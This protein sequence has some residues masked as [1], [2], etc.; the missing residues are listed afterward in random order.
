MEVAPFKGVHLPQGLCAKDVVS[1]CFHP[2]L[3]SVYVALKG[4]VV[5]YDIVTGSKV[6]DFPL[7]VP[8]MEMMVLP[9][10]TALV[11]CNVDGSVV[12]IDFT[13]GHILAEH[14]TKGEK[15]E[16]RF[17][18][19]TLYGSQ[20]IF[21]RVKSVSAFALNLFSTNKKLQ[22]F[23]GHN[24]AITCMSTHP[25]LPLLV[26]A[27][28][29]GTVRVFEIT[30]HGLYNV[31][32]AER[33]NKDT[34]KRYCTV[35]FHTG[36]SQAGKKQRSK[37]KGI[38]SYYKN[39]KLLLVAEKSLIIYYDI[40]IPGAPNKLRDFYAPGVYYRDAC[41]HP[42]DSNVIFSMDH[43]G[44]Y[45]A[46]N[47]EGSGV[48][49][50]GNT[51][52]VSLQP[53]Q[54]KKKSK[55]FKPNSCAFSFL[56][57]N[58]NIANLH[59]PVKGTGR[60]GIAMHTA[61]TRNAI[62][63]AVAPHCPYHCFYGTEVG[64]D[65]ARC[66]MIYKLQ[67]ASK[68]YRGTGAPLITAISPPPEYWVNPCSRM[69]LPGV[70]YSLSGRG[71]N[72]IVVRAHD[73]VS[74]THETTVFTPKTAGGVEM[75]HCTPLAISHST[76][77]HLDITVKHNG[78]E[79]QG[80]VYKTTMTPK[81]P[82]DK[83][84]KQEGF[85]TDT[86]TVILSIKIN[87]ETVIAQCANGAGK[88]YLQKLKAD[89]FVPI[90]D[91]DKTILLD[92]EEYFHEAVVMQDGGHIG[93]ATTSRVIIVDENL[94][95]KCVRA[96]GGY[97]PS[98]AA[99]HWI[100]SCLCFTT[101]CNVFVMTMNGDVSRIASIPDCSV[102][103]GVLYDRLLVATAFDGDDVAI[104]SKH[105][106][107]FETLCKGFLS[108]KPD[109]R[110]SLKP[111]TASYNCTQATQSLLHRLTESGLG[112]LA[113]QLSNYSVGLSGNPYINST[114]REKSKLHM[115]SGDLP[116]AL[117]DMKS[118]L[119][120]LR[121]EVL[122][123]RVNSVSNF[124][125]PPPPGPFIETG[126]LLFQCAVHTNDTPTAD[127]VL[128]LMNHPFAVLAY[129]RKVND[130][131]SLAKLAE[132]SK[133]SVVK[134][135]AEKLPEV[136]KEKRMKY[137]VPALKK[138][139]TW[140]I[141]TTS[142]GVSCMET[143]DGEE[144]DLPRMDL[145]DLKSFVWGQQPLEHGEAGLVQ[146]GFQESD[147]D[148]GED[149]EIE[150]DEFAFPHNADDDVKSNEGD[151]DEIARQQE[152]LRRQY[153]SSFAGEDGE[154]N[155][156]EEDDD[157]FGTQRKFKKFTI[158]K[159][160]VYKQPTL[161]S[162]QLGFGIPQPKQQPDQSKDDTSS[163][164]ASPSPH[165]EK[166]PPPS[167]LGTSPSDCLRNAM[168]KLEKSRFPDAIKRLEA[169]RFYL[170]EDATMVAKKTPLIQ[171]THYILCCR[172]L[173]EVKQLEKDRFEDDVKKCAV[174]TFL[175]SKLPLQKKHVLQCVKLGVRWC[176][177]ACYYTLAK[178]IIESSTD[179]ETF[180]DQLEQCIASA[181]SDVSPS[182]EPYFS[183][184]DQSFC[185]KTFALFA[186]GGADTTQTTCTYC[187]AV[188]SGGTPGT[189]CEFCD[190]GETE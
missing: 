154:A 103:A 190:Y 31:I 86:A 160:A 82:P 88:V 44:C 19:V 8:P 132:L 80:G 43:K 78:R 18:C 112:D 109:P 50:G 151:E 152:E 81:G 91:N 1:V 64:K 61:A 56:S 25:T 59:I 187:P 7:S 106:N 77:G 164:P 146:E 9:S 116:S 10:R 140:V 5:E 55:V 155:G 153:L 179:S 114:W 157:G 159:E 35:K 126:I 27:A 26:C 174:I 72:K 167:F 117:K 67:S 36:G 180:D 125:P 97:T 172:I 111:L 84:V 38:T 145:T 144:K 13:D 30:S 29:D 6:G 170:I 156:E 122:G 49:K 46:L 163:N 48:A 118:A 175:A 12:V 128:E 62:S 14:L 21:S 150:N 119:E 143:I 148:D 110:S 105:A 173:A 121:G 99:I 186:D 184:T 166:P 127:G 65:S 96:P 104:W 16:R 39:V 169:A 123:L 68:R 60:H 141:G 124:S 135:I 87:E 28:V 32:E 90:P 17:E 3:P 94:A 23:T 142:D 101:H 102:I 149:D 2:M 134:K 63:V 139:Q 79:G 76:R 177:E 89:G 129:L 54:D 161:S 4:S 158:N 171:V 85:T 178:H 95:I 131:R 40:S 58:E 83:F 69:V 133:H 41:F 53:L 33:E 115:L 183:A 42:G 108:H 34:V 100:G 136:I 92:P 176:M 66:L 75:E 113:A 182:S 107:H 73:I 189:T 71:K 24:T 188:I 137:P 120:N 51:P 57:E 181:A 37:K 74:S 20:L 70:V 93:I 138:T 165:P 98:I 52:G 45:S 162:L 147:D 11:V 130:A 47:T 22:G 185:W 15:G 168:T